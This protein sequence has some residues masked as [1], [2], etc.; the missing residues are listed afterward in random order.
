MRQPGAGDRLAEAKRLP[1]RLSRRSGL[2]R[3]ILSAAVT[4]SV[5][6]SGGRLAISWCHALIAK[7]AK[8]SGISR[9]V[10]GS[11]QLAGCA[12][13]AG[14]LRLAR[15]GNLYVLDLAKG[16]GSAKYPAWRA[17]V[18]GFPVVVDGSAHH[19]QRGRD[20]SFAWEQSQLPAGSQQYK[21]GNLGAFWAVGHWSLA[22]F[23]VPG[24]SSQA[25]RSLC[26]KEIT[27]SLFGVAMLLWLEARRLGP[28]TRRE[29]RCR[30]S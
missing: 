9:R 19:R 2:S 17:D 25:D 8:K 14:L 12:G 10:E 21:G 28:M 5:C 1:G 18:T 16:T 4:D 13:P 29:T 7:Q 23:P 11:G 27:L 15:T 30:T 24:I 3:S 20:W 26:A 22:S 6:V